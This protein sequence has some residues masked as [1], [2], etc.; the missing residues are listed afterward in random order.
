M[1]IVRSLH[2][3]P[4]KS[5]APINLGST[6][7]D[8]WG[9]SYDRQLALVDMNGNG[10]TARTH[11]QIL[12]LHPRI[13]GNILLLTYKNKGIGAIPLRQGSETEYQA[14]KI[15]SYDAFGMAVEEDAL[16]DFICNLIGIPCRIMTVSQLKNRPVLEKHGGLKDETLA[17]ADQAPIL[18]VSKA[19]LEDLNTRATSEIKMQQFRPNIVISGVKAGE[20]DQ[21]KRIQIGQDVRL[22]LIQ[23]CERCIFTTINPVSLEKD[24]RGEPLRTLSK[25]R[26]NAKKNAV[27]GM[28][29][30]VEEEG[31]INTGD[32]IRI[33]E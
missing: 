19:S 8:K 14:F 31:L 22:R 29:A 24:P 7:A 30:V 4:L 25:Y 27:F 33:L 5:G 6:Q 26:L 20:E 3:Y 11:P 10:I 16:T 21:W 15:F 23:Q 9:L 2:T 18:L 13:S 17:F 28:H 1:P 32:Q 12:H